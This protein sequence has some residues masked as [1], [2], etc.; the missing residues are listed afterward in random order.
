MFSGCTYGGSGPDAID[1]GG[2]WIFSNGAW[3][4]NT[5][6]APPPACGASMAYDSARDQIILFGGA[7]LASS[8]PSYTYRQDTWAWN[9]TGWQQ[10]APTT[11]PTT[12]WRGVMAEDPIHH[13]LIY[14]TGVKYNGLGDLTGGETWIWDGTNWTHPADTGSPTGRYSPVM[15]WNPARRR[16]VF[17]GGAFR[18]LLMTP[19]ALMAEWDGTRWNIVPTGGN[20]A[21]RYAA[22][23]A[24][25]RD[26][27]L[28]LGGGTSQGTTSD[29]LLVRHDSDA[30]PETCTTADSDGDGLGGCADP[31]CWYACTPTCMPGVTCTNPPLLCGNATCDPSE[32]CASCEADCGACPA[33]C[34]NYVCDESAASCPGDCP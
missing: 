34:G 18:N 19:D 8:A 15:A 14:Y 3:S 9:G 6:Q 31:D 27:I 4:K 17:I 13:Q 23:G 1:D 33:R 16:L 29:A 25:W 28:V 7:V 22:A 10:L 26:G 21:A 11:H 24:A 2:T 12:G 20:E 5:G 30:P 32:T